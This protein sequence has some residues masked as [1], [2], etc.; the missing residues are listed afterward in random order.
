MSS[1]QAVL[2]ALTQK[3]MGLTYPTLIGT[4]SAVQFL[5]STAAG[6]YAAENAVF[7]GLDPEGAEIVHGTQTYAGLGGMVKYETYVILCAVSCFVGGSLGPDDTLLDS[8]DAQNNARANAY[9][10]FGVIEQAIID[11]KQFLGVASPPLNASGPAM[12]MWSDV[13]EL[14][15]IAG[16]AKS[17]DVVIGRSADISFTVTIHARLLFS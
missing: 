10:I 11:D 5:D 12:V 15:C 7:I 8:S 14:G 1:H 13:N 4:D 9:A 3:V 17:K 6:G 16:L 2:V